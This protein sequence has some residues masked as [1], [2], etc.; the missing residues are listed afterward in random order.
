LNN[1]FPCA[2]CQY[3]HTSA[4]FI[5]RTLSIVWVEILDCHEKVVDYRS[6]ARRID[7][8]VFKAIHH[9]QARAIE[10]VEPYVLP[11]LE[12]VSPHAWRVSFKHR[13]DSGTLYRMHLHI[14]LL[15]VISYLPFLDAKEY[16]GIVYGCANQHY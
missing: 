8:L 10:C 9:V 2:I 7:G 6:K 5:E 4:L 12:G 1:D 15:R 13:C 14:I 3:A 16:V 11:F